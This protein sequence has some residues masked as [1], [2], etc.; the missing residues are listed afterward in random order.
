MRT[1]STIVKLAAVAL[2]LHGL[3]RV[4]ASYWRYYQLDD[5][6]REV[7]Q[8]AFQQNESEVQA[9]VAA[10]AASLAVSV[11]AEDVQVRKT[12]REIV[13]DLSYVDQVQILP[14]YSY[15]WTYT[16]HVHA[17]LNP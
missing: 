2:L 17:F 7:A 4:G 9:K 8:F 6:V 3:W 15:P 5:G 16:V 11:Q 10:V 1:I 12:V 14:R 13:V